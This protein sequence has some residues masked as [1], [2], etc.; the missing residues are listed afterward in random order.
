[1]LVGPLPKGGQPGGKRVKLDGFTYRH[2]HS[3]PDGSKKIWFLVIGGSY[4]K[5]NRI[6]NSGGVSICEIPLDD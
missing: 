4:G 6:I 2:S 5:Y 1:M 3:A